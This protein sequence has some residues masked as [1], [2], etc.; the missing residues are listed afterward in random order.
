MHA[1]SLIPLGTAF[2]RRSIPTCVASRQGTRPHQIFPSKGL[3]R[4]RW[5]TSPAAFI[6]GPGHIDPAG[7][8]EPP[9]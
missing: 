3:V 1:D 6:L 4:Q 8:T 2:I 7:S 5:K 9:V